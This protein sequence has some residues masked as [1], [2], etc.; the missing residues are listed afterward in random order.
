MERQRKERKE[1]E[2]KERV[3]R[4]GGRLKGTVGLGHMDS[5]D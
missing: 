5:E 4:E 1:R 3:A 2:E